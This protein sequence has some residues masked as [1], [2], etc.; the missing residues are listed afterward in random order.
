MMVT[1]KGEPERLQTQSRDSEAS[2]SRL[3][4][5]LTGGGRQAAGGL[6]GSRICHVLVGGHV[7]PPLVGPELEADT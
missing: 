6:I 2:V 7:S 3:L 5:A 4:C 1:P